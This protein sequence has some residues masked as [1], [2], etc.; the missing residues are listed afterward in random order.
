MM[1][2]NVM[3]FVVGYDLVCDCSDNS[4]TRYL[5]SDA[6]ASAEILFVSVVCVGFEG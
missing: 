4:R 1:M 5:L 6:C 2:E 3:E